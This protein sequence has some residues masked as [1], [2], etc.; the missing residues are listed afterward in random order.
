MR[1]RWQDDQVDFVI[2]KTGQA[3]TSVAIVYLARDVAT[4]GVM[5]LGRLTDITNLP[6]PKANV[7]AWEVQRVNK[8]CD[9]NATEFLR[10]VF[11]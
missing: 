7:N 4:T 3:A 5:M 6:D 1:C 11:L 2:A 8:T 10:K 9:V